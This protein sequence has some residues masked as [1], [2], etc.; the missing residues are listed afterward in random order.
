MLRVL[1]RE[2]VADAVSHVRR[3]Q[4]MTLQQVEQ[5]TSLSRSTLLRMMRRGDLNVARAGRRVWVASDEVE[6]LIDEGI[7]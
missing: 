6:R 7:R 5:A 4:A 2:E 3:P 1:V